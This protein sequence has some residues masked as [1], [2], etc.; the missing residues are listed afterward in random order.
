MRI[1]AVLLSLFFPGAGHGLRGYWLRG[2]ACAGAA[3]LVTLLLPWGGW[4][5]LGAGLIVRLVT[6]VDSARGAPRPFDWM[7][8]GIGLGLGMGCLLMPRMLWVEGFKIPSGAMIPT[9]QVGDHLFV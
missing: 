4:W 3:L 8:L 5:A 9:L 7:S 2:A 1:L 6:M